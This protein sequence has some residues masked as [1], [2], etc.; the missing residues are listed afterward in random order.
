MDYP[1]S[2]PP[3]KIFIIGG[4]GVLVFLLLLVLIVTQALKNKL[5]ATATTTPQAF[6]A[7]EQGQEA[8]R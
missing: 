1:Q 3:V 5:T 8:K 7:G 6:R 4:V 2:S